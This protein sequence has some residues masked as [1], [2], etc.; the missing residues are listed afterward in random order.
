MMRRSK[1]E[2]NPSAIEQAAQRNWNE[3]YS[4]HRVNSQRYFALS[5]V[6]VCVAGLAVARLWYLDTQ[7]KFIPY[8]IDRNGP[9]LLTARLEA[10]MPDAARIKGHL[11]TWVMGMRTV[12]NDLH[13]QKHLVD[14]TYG[15]IDSESIAHQQLNDWYTANNPYVRMK[16]TT[17]DVDI[18]SVVSQ[19]GEGWLVDWTETTYT[20]PG[21]PETKSYWRMTVIAHV[22]LPESQEE[23]EAD[24][25]GVWVKEFHI[26]SLEHKV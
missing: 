20:Q 12:V 13:Y 3:A 18:N 11:T 16:T 25:D 7:P 9:S 21:K 4:Y 8:V 14:Q 10:H 1:R 24:W 26:Q 6:C 15:W 23:F 2:F 5:I 22:R 17:V 19:D